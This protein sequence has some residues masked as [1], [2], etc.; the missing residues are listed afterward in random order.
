M[1]INKVRLRD[2][3]KNYEIMEQE[4][5]YAGV[6]GIA[7]LLGWQIV[8]FCKK[9]DPVNT[10]AISFD[11]IDNTELINIA[12]S[13][14]EFIDANVR[15]GDNIE[16]INRAYGIADFMDN[17]YEDMIRY[18]YIIS[19]NLFIGFGLKYNALSCLEIVTDEN[20]IKEIISVR[21]V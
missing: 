12:N 4:F 21:M 15:F 14:L 20:M 16:T 13:I 10:V 7:E 5:E 9:D 2:I 17:L 1:K 3:I 6:N 8:S 11:E 19:P 18:N